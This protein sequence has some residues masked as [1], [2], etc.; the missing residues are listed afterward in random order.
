MNATA[1]LL[2]S[3]LAAAAL[4]AGCGSDSETITVTETQTVAASTDTTSATGDSTSTEPSAETTS[5]AEAATTTTETTSADETSCPGAESPPN[6]T[7][8]VPVGVDCATVEAAMSQIG[9]ISKTFSLGDFQC[10]RTSGFRLSGIWTCVG[11]DGSFTF[12]FGD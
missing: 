6:I 2:G 8:V 9:S 1:V 12:D 10:Q 4:L 5:T 3:A 11:V 7:N